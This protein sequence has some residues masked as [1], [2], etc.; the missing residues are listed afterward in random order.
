MRV[1]ADRL[2]AATQSPVAL[3]NMLREAA[4]TNSKVTLEPRM[5]SSGAPVGGTN[6]SDLENRLRQ[7]QERRKQLEKQKGVK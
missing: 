3:A 6:L 2:S 1:A 7:L 5:F 4:D